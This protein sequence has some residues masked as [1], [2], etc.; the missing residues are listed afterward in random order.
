MQTPRSSPGQLRR[1]DR[2]CV[3]QQQHGVGDRGDRVNRRVSCVEF[4]IINQGGPWADK[5]TATMATDT[6]SDKKA[7]KP[8]VGLRKTKG[9]HV[10]VDSFT[11]H[12]VVQLA[13]SDGRVLT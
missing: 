10:V 4:V 2:G 11:R 6:G 7:H 9:V 5:D 3:E 13:Q 8:A 12:A 1:S